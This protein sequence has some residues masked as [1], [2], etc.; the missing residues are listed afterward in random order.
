MLCALDCSSSES[1]SDGLCGEGEPPPARWSPL[2]LVTWR[3]LDPSPVDSLVG[4][5][6]LTDEPFP[7]LV[8]VGPALNGSFV[9]SGA[10]G[11]RTPL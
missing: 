3:S 1:W 7:T 6:N 5:I 9:P 10:R 11:V 2:P 4:Q 8:A